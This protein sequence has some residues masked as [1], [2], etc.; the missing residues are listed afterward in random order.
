M[1]KSLLVVL[2]IV[3][4]LITMACSCSFAGLPNLMRGSLSP[5][6]EIVREERDVTGA[7]TTVEI[8]GDGTLYFTQ[9][10]TAA[11]II[12]GD[13]NFVNNIET[14]IVDDTLI[15]RPKDQFMWNWFRE[16]EELNY[17][18]TLPML[19]TFESS[20]AL[21]V[22]LGDITM[23]DLS[24]SFSGSSDL[25]ADFI[26]AEDLMIS[27]SGSTKVIIGEIEAEEF[28]GKFSGSADF[29]AVAMDALAIR[30]DT[31]AAFDLQVGQMN[32]ESEVSIDTSGSADMAIGELYALDLMLDSSGSASLLI[33]EGTVDSQSISMS[34]SGTYDAADLQSREAYLDSSGSVEFTLWVMDYLSIDSS[35]SCDVNYYGDP[36]ID[37]NTSGNT[38]INAL[39]NAKE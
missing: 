31:S 5:S 16:P 6:G 28:L 37:Q 32:A 30:F 29:E 10:E 39:D 33:E 24:L 26:V 12:E 14:R 3:L 13:T 25:F 21:D 15:I 34:G 22:D 8:S 19:E 9:G 38:S 7:I 2:I 1:K 4:A 11:L 17:Y 23:G 18:L 27:G 36:E 35:G 20:G